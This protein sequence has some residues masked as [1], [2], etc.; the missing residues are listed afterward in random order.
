MYGLEVI[1]RVIFLLILIALPLSVLQAAS[2]AAWPAHRLRGANITLT[3]TA[4]DLEHFVQDWKGNSVRILVNDLLSDKAP[5]DPSPADKQKVYDCID[6]CLKYGLYT[7]FSPSAAFRDNDK[8][9]GDEAYK[10][11]YI[12]YWRELASRYAADPGG[13]AYDLMNEPHDNL[14]RTQWTAFARELTAVIRAVDTLHTIIVEPPDWGWPAGFDYLE[15]TGDRNTVYSFHFYGPMDYTHQRNQGMLKATEQQ[16]RGRVYPGQLQGEYWDKE[17]I[18]A[19]FEKAFQ[20]RDRYSVPIWCG[21]FGVAR[22]AIGAAQ[23]T[24]DLIDILEEQRVGWA[25][26]S[27]R[28]WYAMDIEMSPEARNQRTERTETELV[29]LYKSYFAR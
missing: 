16:W 20:F 26:Y 7:V 21:E 24:R 23:W 12:S 1:M 27:Y 15:P 29:K 2:P 22:W 10:E 19:E 13:V 17:K 4:E 18:R 14:A 9:F 8:F 28:E 11:A 5:Y 3:I 25:Y 6:L